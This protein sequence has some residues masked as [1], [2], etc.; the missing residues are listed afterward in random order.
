MN[1]NKKPIY[2]LTPCPF[3][4][5]EDIR[6]SI[7]VTGRFNEKRYHA[8]FYC[9]SC[10]CYGPRILSDVVIGYAS[11]SAIEQDESLKIKAAEAWDNRK[12]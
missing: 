1:S 6:Y 10:H 5:G 12:L 8:S 11:R 2:K 9:N 4:G 3:C 7:K